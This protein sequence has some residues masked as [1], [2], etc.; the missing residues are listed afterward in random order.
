M[1]RS[2]SSWPT[3]A[4]CSPT[5]CSSTRL[6]H[7]S[8][9]AV[10]SKVR[11][12]S[13]SRSFRPG[14]SAGIGLPKR[15]SMPAMASGITRSWIRTRVLSRYTRPTGRSTDQSSATKDTQQC[16]PRSSRTSRSIS[17]ASGSERRDARPRCNNMASCVPNAAG[18]RSVIQ[19]GGAEC[20][21]EAFHSW[22][23]GPIPMRASRAPRECGRRRSP[24]GIVA[25][26]RER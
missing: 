5:S 25:I 14:R 20:D 13:P 4:S 18:T 17:D 11:R 24:S 1:L 22:C 8:S 15:R 3:R 9:V 19:R 23:T 2:T 12:T 10:G 7:R 26:T 6:V 16:A 21:T